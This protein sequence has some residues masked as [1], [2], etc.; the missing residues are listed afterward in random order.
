M[1]G[2][3]VSDIKASRDA[4]VKIAS[5]LWDSYAKEKVASM[6][7]DLVFHTVAELD[8]WLKDHLA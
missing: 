5:V 8:Q 4:G 7:T 1:V 6:T 2:D 3:S